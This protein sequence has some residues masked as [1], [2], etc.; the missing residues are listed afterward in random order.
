MLPTSSERSVGSTSRS[1]R[2]AKANTYIAHVLVGLLDGDKPE[3]ILVEAAKAAARTCLIRGAFGHAPAMSVDLS[4][5]T[6]LEEIYRAARP[7]RAP[8]DV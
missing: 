1:F 2:R 3:A 7:A 4:N 5:M 8:E 6:S